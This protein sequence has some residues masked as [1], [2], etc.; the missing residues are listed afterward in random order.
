MCKLG[1]IMTRRTDPAPGRKR[2]VYG[3][4]ERAR[5]QVQPARKA[6]R[7]PLRITIKEQF[8]TIPPAHVFGLVGQ[9]LIAAVRKPVLP[10]LHQGRCGS[11]RTLKTAKPGPGTLPFHITQKVEPRQLQTREHG[12]VTGH[13]I[14]GAQMLRWRPSNRLTLKTAWAAVADVDII[15]YV[16][17]HNLLGIAVRNHIG[18]RPDLDLDA[19]FFAPLARER[20]LRRLSRDDLAARKLPLPGAHLAHGA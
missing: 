10:K 19:E 4:K 1:G 14:L 13:E 16:Q 2:P 11:E 12:A 17:S 20:G 5:R 18:A 8:R 6:S 15:K 9:P 3:S 7:N